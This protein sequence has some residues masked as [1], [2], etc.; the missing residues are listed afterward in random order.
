MLHSP[1][2][3][4]ADRQRRT[5]DVHLADERRAANLLNARVY[6]L[7]RQRQARI[8]GELPLRTVRIQVEGV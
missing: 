3:R 7:E 4:V 8:P 6:I 1:V 2:P 5:I